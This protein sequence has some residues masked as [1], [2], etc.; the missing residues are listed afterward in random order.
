VA[1]AGSPEGVEAAGAIAKTLGAK[2][3]VP[4][5][6]GGAF[7][8]PFMAPARDRLRKALMH[9]AFHGPDPVV[10]ANVDAR[11]HPDEEE[12]RQLLS[13]QLCAPVRWRQTLEQ[14]YGSG[15][16]TFVEL[17]PGGV[18]S[19]LARRALPSEEIAAVS[20]AT[21]S[22]LDKLLEVVAGIEPAQAAASTEQGEQL[23]MNERLV[24]SPATG[25]FRP[26]PALDA[27]LP[28]ADGHGDSRCPQLGVG[29]LVGYVGETEV[30]SAWAGALAGI[31]V[32]PGERVADGQPV[33]WL[34]TGTVESGR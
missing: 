17:G 11:P 2:K 26:A 14:L 34:R 5:P 4:L 25:L 3:V 15:M 9:V 19:G 32:L 18:L 33:A 6:V 31:L 20:V 7:H 27:S 1:I 12:W 16:R 22:D 10:V 13:A 23:S 30:R 28:G 21:P 29:D 24:V 8:T